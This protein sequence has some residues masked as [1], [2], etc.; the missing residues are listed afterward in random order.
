MEIITD[1]RKFQ[2]NKVFHKSL[3]PRETATI[4]ATEKMLIFG[5]DTENDVFIIIKIAIHY[6]KI[7][8][9]FRRKLQTVGKISPKNGV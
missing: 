3:Q 5:A 9:L 6:S 7:Y 8:F 2:L 1:K 4:L